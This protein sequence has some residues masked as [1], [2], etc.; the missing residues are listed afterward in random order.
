MAYLFLQ[1]SQARVMCDTLRLFD[2]LNDKASI[3][4]L[5]AR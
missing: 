1:R 4:V 5:A 3:A 2:A